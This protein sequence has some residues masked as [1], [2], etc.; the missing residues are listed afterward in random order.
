MGDGMSSPPPEL[1]LPPLQSQNL[2]NHAA[3]PSLHQWDLDPNL[4]WFGDTGSN[5]SYPNT[6]WNQ[7]ETVTSS[8]AVA[9]LPTIL[10]PETTPSFST[11]TTDQSNSLPSL[12]QHT[13]TLPPTRREKICPKEVITYDPQLPMNLIC[14]KCGQRFKKKSNMTTHT[15]KC[16]TQLQTAFKP[17]ISRARPIKHTC[18]ICRLDLQSKTIL[19]SHMKLQHECP[20]CSASC[21]SASDVASHIAHAHM[22]K[23][24]FCLR[25]I[26]PSSY[27]AP[28]TKIKPSDGTI[29]T[30][31]VS[32]HPATPDIDM[33]TTP[34]SILPTTSLDTQDA[35]LP[36]YTVIRENDTSK[37][38]N[39][40][41]SELSKVTFTSSQTPLHIASIAGATSSLNYLLR[42]TRP[43]LINFRDINGESPL[44]HA[45]RLG[46]VECMESLIEAGACLLN[47]NSLGRTPFHTTSFTGNISALNCLIDHYENPPI[48]ALRLTD[49]FGRTALHL[50]CMEGHLKVVEYLLLHGA[51]NEIPDHDSHTPA[52]LARINHRHACLYMLAEAPH[53]PFPL[54]TPSQRPNHIPPAR[55]GQSGPH[56]PSDQLHPQASTQGVTSDTEHPIAAEN[57]T[58]CS[59]RCYACF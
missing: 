59:R 28:I 1:T 52:D 27:S 41:C 21:S 6:Q 26:K 53:T 25:P 47:R 39:F 23:C 3:L 20:Y 9:Y 55:T 22:H 38:M 46:H 48:P 40:R 11:P 19:D 24:Q 34:P 16:H 5:P 8:E 36:I 2:Q 42:H 13:F 43:N 10:N 15:N 45:A 32:I 12:A 58:K 31:P 29:E 54:F 14:E 57:R 37:L 4:N 35:D 50:A 30:H 7:Q 49:N 51:M 17:P 33:T 44:S 56:S 18:H